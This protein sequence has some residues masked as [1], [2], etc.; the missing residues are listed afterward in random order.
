MT[1]TRQSSAAAHELAALIDGNVSEDGVHLTAIPRVSLIRSSQPT[2]PLHVV[3]QP[4]VCFVAQGRKQVMVGDAI[5]VYDAAKY[6]V[7]SV[8]VPIV[9]QVLEATSEPPLPLS[10]PRPR[11]GRH[12]CPDARCRRR[13]C[14]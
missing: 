11:S 1:Q 6:L 7:V 12:R 14:P 9:G 10:A 5:H 3:H 8:E 13:T 4:A 2:E